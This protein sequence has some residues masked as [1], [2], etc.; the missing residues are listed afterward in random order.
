MLTT[1]LQTLRQR[2]ML[3]AGA[4]VA[5]ALGVGLIASTT[6]VLIASTRPAQPSDALD[7]VPSLMAV[8]ASIACFV[9]V[10]VVASTFAF[11]VAQR[12]REVALLR[13]VGATPAQVRRMLLGEALALGAV[14]SLAG[15]AL[16]VPGS[17]LL[18]SMLVRSGLAP[19][20]FQAPPNGGAL[21]LAFGL[22]LGI[23]LLG[24]LLASRR[25]GKVHAVEALR[26]AAVDR[27]VMTT[28][29][30]FVGLSFA[31]G[32]V[33]M[34]VLTPHLGMEGATAVSSMTAQVLVVGLA[35]LAPLLV[36]PVVWLV[37]LL[38]ARLTTASGL[39]ARQ[40]ARAALRRTASTAAP[41]MVAV[42]ITGSVLTTLATMGAS[43]VAS[44]TERTTA[45]LVVL[46][47]GAPGLARSTVEAVRT[48]DG[49][50][51]ASPGVSTTLFTKDPGDLAL[52]TY[53]AEAVD[54]AAYLATQRRGVQAGSLAELRGS[55]VAVSNAHAATYGW[56]LGERIDSRLADGTPVRLRVVAILEDALGT[57]EVLLPLDLA[58]PH[59]NPALVD[60]VL[61][62]V[63][64][65][66][67]PAQV[68]AA[69]RAELAGSGAT[70]TTSG[71]W[72]A[73][74]A[75]QAQ[76]ANR[77]AIVVLLGM[78][79]AYTMIAIANTMVMA[80]SQRR[81][82]LAVLRLGGVTTAQVLRA[83][84]WET[85][86]VLAVGVGFGAVAAAASVLGIWGALAQL[87]D[88]ARLV[89]PW[90]WLLAVVGAAAAVALLA[91]LLPARLALRQPP[92][93]LAGIRE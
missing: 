49:V 47:G 57:P 55:V 31:G 90:G 26:D 28:S 24:V 64:D 72:L 83:L 36:P 44:V 14:A 21:L 76:R 39:L 67:D 41:V 23:A 50:A 58:L 29:R 81:R 33:A 88:A 52:D 45:D 9:A 11:T 80:A 40:H 13:L 54:P 15:C 61:V 2:W 32:G 71:A 53:D 84:T 12:R 35:A 69:V 27:R 68:A 19:A 56:R 70:V 93:Q 63:R 77:F 46:P 1:A 5:L 8:T 30:W 10:F 51:A 92:V 22:G 62:A 91:S 65:G 20:W 75:A 74:S 82:E 78:S 79:T 42:A 87:G 18:A 48:A 7:D 43:T 4:F 89:V 6:T 60:S 73:A 38:P 86:M 37:G 3:F 85:V 16:S 34:T 66:N 17:R 25:A 59:Q